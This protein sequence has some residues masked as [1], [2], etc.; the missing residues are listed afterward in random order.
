[1]AIVFQKQLQQ[2]LEAVKLIVS[3]I[4]DSMQRLDCT[5]VSTKQERPHGCSSFKMRM[6]N[7][8]Q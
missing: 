6:G 4:R 5:K 1:M 7:I 2:L 3:E 8:S